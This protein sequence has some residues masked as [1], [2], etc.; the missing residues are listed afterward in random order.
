MNKSIYSL[1]TILIALG[2][3]LGCGK[4]DYVTAPSA[5]GGIMLTS[6]GSI[7]GSNRQLWGLWH[8]YMQPGSGRIDVVPLRS[9]T[10]TA[11]V[12]NL[13]E[14]HPGNLQISD[15][16]LTDFET[17][18]LLACTVTLRHPLPGLDQF[19]G[20]DVWGVFI[21][22]GATDM[23][24]DGLTYSGG[25]AAGTNEAVLLN[26]D[27]L[28]RWFN[29]PEFDGDGLPILE[30]WPGK[31]SNLPAPTATLNPYKVFADGL[32][33]EDNFYEWATTPGNLDDR[34]IYRAGE[35]H[36]RRYELDFPII[37]DDPVVDFQ[38]AVIATW[39]PGDP[40]LTGQPA[41]YDPFDFP[42]SANCEEAFL[43]NVS[44]VASDLYYVDATDLGGT[45]RADIEVFDWQGGSVGGN[46]IPNEVQSIIVEGDF[47]PGGVYQWSQSELAT[48]AVAATENSSVFQIEL[49]DCTPVSSVESEIWVIVEAAGQ[50]GETY[51]QDFG[52]EYP[53]GACRAA[54]IPSMVIMDDE[55]PEPPIT[56]HFELDEGGLLSDY[57]GYDDISPALAWETDDK[58]RCIWASDH[59]Y[60]PHP[61]SIPR[62]MRSDDGG[63]NWLENQTYGSHGNVRM[64]DHTKLTPADN[65]NS[66]LL[67]TFSWKTTDDPYYQAGRTGDKSISW[68][69]A[70]MFIGFDDCGEVICASDGC[71]HAFGD[72][73]TGSPGI[74]QKIGNQQWTWFYDWTGHPTPPPNWWWP[75]VPS[76]QV[77]PGPAHVSDTRSIGDDSTGTI[78][79]AY[80]AG[81]SDEF[82]KLT[83][84]TDG[85]TGLDWEQFTAYQETGYSSVRDPGLKV[86]E[87]DVLHIAFLRNND[88]TG[89]DEVCYIYSTDGG[90]NWS[91]VS[92]VH[93]SPNEMTDTPIE[94]YEAYDHSILAIA[95]EDGES[96]WFTYSFDG[97]DTWADPELISYEGSSVDQ[98][99]D[100]VVGTDNNLHFAWAH[101][102]TVDW[103][104]HFRNAVLIED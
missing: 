88:T 35:V 80:W 64:R 58:L 81:L 3:I 49:I 44:T 26:P 52:T 4:G 25:P 2:L 75:E 66:F 97:G 70:N 90:V 76:H 43:L 31:L 104:I 10:F 1:M 91:D 33:T 59:L 20:F 63:Q 30:Y 32:G 37:D 102:G 51:D 77:T 56:V 73:L 89:E 6:Q 74:H 21:H 62:G 29:Y 34:G 60:E 19:H 96:V 69:Y 65:G 94:A 68:N 9:A 38:Y 27:G 45:F 11:N 12:N 50:S 8:C 53:E 61:Y 41:A 17:E 18:G 86:D 13:L 47:L 101:E 14:D 72:E 54:L 100:M 78:Y 82:I 39:E 93:T 99:P 95:F 79:L 42:T 48:V 71:V 24:Y 87:N 92:V 46:G 15:M 85:A 83:R 28:T 40:T 23:G 67:Y 84:S 5:D 36:S 7:T 98:M 103:E 55:S 57:V 16:D 22:N